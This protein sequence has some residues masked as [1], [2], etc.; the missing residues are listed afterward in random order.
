MQY[1]ICLKLENMYFIIAKLSPA[2]A[3]VRDVPFPPSGIKADTSKIKYQISCGASI[4][5]KIGRGR[6]QSSGS[7][8]KRRIQCVEKLS[9]YF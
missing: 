9:F 3:S 2:P 4:K 1:F 7:H 8:R 5:N 6:A